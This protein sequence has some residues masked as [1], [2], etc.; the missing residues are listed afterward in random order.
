MKWET[1][2]KSEQDNI[3]YCSNCDRG[4]YFCK[5]D[6]ELSEALSKNRCVAIILKDETN[7]EPTKTEPVHTIGLVRTPPYL[8]NINSKPKD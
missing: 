7:V 3:R 5:T 6:G 1:L 8:I 2:L 4:V